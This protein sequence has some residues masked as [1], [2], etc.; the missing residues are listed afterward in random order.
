MNR[1][2]IEFEFA[3]GERVHVRDS[4]DIVCRVIGQCNRVYGK[5]YCVC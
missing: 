3:I 5:T 1:K 4:V 2:T